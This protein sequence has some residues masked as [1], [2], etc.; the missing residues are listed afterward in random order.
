MQNSESYFLKM[1]NDYKED[2]NKKINEVRKLNQDL[3]KKVSN[4][5]GKFRREMQT[6]EGKKLEMKNSINQIK[7]I[8]G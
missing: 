6:V 1:I 2:L 8:I 3:D 7:T 4:M 5:N